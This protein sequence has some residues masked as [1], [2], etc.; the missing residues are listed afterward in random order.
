MAD[1]SHWD[2]AEHFR[3]KEAAELIMGIPPEKNNGWEELLG[4][5]SG[6]TAKITP[7]LRR[8]ER[9]LNGGLNTLHAAAIW[10]G[11]AKDALITFPHVPCELHSETMVKARESATEFGLSLFKNHDWTGKFGNAYFSRSEIARWLDAI[12]MKSVYQFDRKLSTK[13]DADIETDI[14][15]ADLPDELH[16]A[17][18]AFRA[19]TNGYGDPL[20]TFRNR[21]IGYLETNF[22]ALSNDAVKRISTVANPDKTTGR[23]KSTTE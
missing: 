2:F 1:L 16:A 17:N 4:G 8:M 19:V 15:P 12:E 5:E 22:P 11:S 21:L 18:I 23:K 20:A 7:L 10:G 14:D 9:A 3:G 13:P 6:Y